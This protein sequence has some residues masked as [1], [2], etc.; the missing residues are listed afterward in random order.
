[1]QCGWI[2]LK[3]WDFLT[4]L[5]TE[6]FILWLLVAF[7]WQI[8]SLGYV[9]ERTSRASSGRTVVGGL[10]SVTQTHWHCIVTDKPWVRQIIAFIYTT[11]KTVETVNNENR[12]HNKFKNHSHQ[13]TLHSYIQYSGLIALTPSLEHG[14]PQ[15][16]FPRSTLCS[17]STES[18]SLSAVHSPCCAVHHTLWITVTRLSN[19][20]YPMALYSAYCMPWTYFTVLVSADYP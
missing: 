2:P 13:I 1:M 12:T 4:C 18:P 8:H 20:G 10:F 17:S 5:I 6:G 14:I 7:Q 3:S 15:I 16:R 19:S 11:D 9:Q